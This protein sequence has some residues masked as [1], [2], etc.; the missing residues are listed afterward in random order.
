M[1]KLRTV[2][3]KAQALVSEQ[4]GQLQTA[5]FVAGTSVAV[6]ELN[7]DESPIDSELLDSLKKDCDSLEDQ[8]KEVRNRPLSSPTELCVQKCIQDF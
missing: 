1:E 2:R 7:D 6:S 8:I 4:Q 3:D 5:K